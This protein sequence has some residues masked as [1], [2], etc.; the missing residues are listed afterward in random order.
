MNK[1]IAMFS[2]RSSGVLLHI[3]SL[4]GMHGSGDLGD[5]AYAFADFL[6]DSRQSWW[7]MLPVGPSGKGPSYSPY[8]SPSAFAGNPLFISLR[9]L[10][11]EGLLG[12]EELKPRKSFSGRSID[13]R[14]VNNFREA[15]LKL[16]HRTFISAG[17]E[18][19]SGYRAFCRKNAYWLEDFSLFMALRE[20]QK[21]NG[22]TAWPE[23]LR[24][25]DS[26]ELVKAS[27]RLS[28]RI[29]YHMFVQFIFSRQWLALKRKCNDL[30]IGLIGDIPIFAAH[31]SSDVWSN[32]SLFQLD[33]NGRAR[34]I[35]GYPPDR[36]NK[37]GQ[38]WGHPQYDWPAHISDGFG[39]WKN[40]F[41][42][43][44]ELFDAVRIDH[45]LGFTRTWS[46]PGRSRTARNGRWVKS[47]G[48]ELFDAVTAGTGPRPMIAEDLGHVTP[49]DISLRMEFGL[50]PMRIFQFGFGGSADSSGHLPHNWDAGCVA[51]TGNHDTNTI[52]GWLG[53]LSVPVRRKVLAYTGGSADTF[54]TDAIRS[55][56]C[57]QARIVIFPVQDILGLGAGGR[58]NVPGTVHGNW[59]WRMNGAIQ[60]GISADLGLM[61]ELFGRAN[62]KGK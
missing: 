24:K 36:F 39:W 8:D 28:E 29:D 20:E 3:T 32:Q 4:P 33:D 31:D 56:M 55:V 22:W 53:S 13:F 18:T 51:Y 5:E 62:N 40:R 44:Y 25:R 57:S 17:G 7:Q 35:S 10:G 61:T 12:N 11:L 47:P 59:N 50:L 19:D 27:V 23:K 30:G 49:A 2:R 9:T 38:L 34:R 52:K 46:V 16:A 54:H 60:E 1:A 42:R 41:S 43:M 21:G 48:H 37:D 14:T 6:A 15:R 58:M 45:F 26:A